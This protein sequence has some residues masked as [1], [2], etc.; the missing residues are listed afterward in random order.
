[1]FKAPFSFK[2]RISR[3]EYFF[4]TFIFLFLYGVTLP[5]IVNSGGLWVLLV[6]AEWWFWLAQGAK[7]CHDFGQAGW[8]QIIPVINPFALWLFQGTAGQN[9]YGPDPRNPDAMAIPSP[10]APPTPIRPPKP[11]QPAYVPPAK[12]ASFRCTS[13][14]AQNKDISYTQSPSCEFCG[15]PHVRK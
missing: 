1:M 8:I 5:A 15:A 6:L 12:L 10:A 3:S 11:N 7:R 13:C 4:S 14:G 9:Q 2:G